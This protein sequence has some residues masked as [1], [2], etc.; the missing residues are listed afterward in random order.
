M[1][2]GLGSVLEAKMWGIL[3]GLK[4]AW[5][6]DFKKVLVESDSQS[7]VLLLN[8]TTPLNYPLFNIIR[9]CKSLLDYDWSCTIHHIYKESNK[10]ADYLANLG[11]SLDLGVTMFEDPT[12]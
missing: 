10:V 4:L 12:P 3:E 8:N 11:H 2:K 7:G 9:A 6:A 1:N 5:K